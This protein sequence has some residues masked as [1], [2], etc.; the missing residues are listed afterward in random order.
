MPAAAQ[1]SSS[2]GLAV[3][4][5]GAMSISPAQRAAMPSPVPGSST[6]TDAGEPLKLNSSA[7]KAV[8]GAT[9]D[10]PEMATSPG[11]VP[12]GGPDE[13]SSGAGP[14]AARKPDA[15]VV[16]ESSTTEVT[17]RYPMGGR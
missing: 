10:E 1:A 3:R 13:G 8:I 7:T 17:V 16:A 9:V 15:R 5:A 4:E 6:T 14:Q 12:A 2:S 11:L